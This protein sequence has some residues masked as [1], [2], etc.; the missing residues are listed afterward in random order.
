MGL[1]RWSGCFFFLIWIQCCLGFL[2]DGEIA[3]EVGF[4]VVRIVSYIFQFS[5]IGLERCEAIHCVEETHI[6]APYGK[7]NDASSRYDSYQRWQVFR[8]I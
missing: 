3:F 2:E 6:W 4:V 5:R 7:L 1:I 8:G